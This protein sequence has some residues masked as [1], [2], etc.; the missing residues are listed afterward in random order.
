MECVYCHKL[1]SNKYTLRTH[2]TTSKKCIA[3]QEETTNTVLQKK[4]LCTHCNKQLTSNERLQHHLTICKQRPSEEEVKLRE[5]IKELEDKL[6]K[7][8]MEPKNIHNTT[9][10]TNMSNSNNTNNTNISIINYM[11]EERVLQIFKDHFQLKDLEQSRLGMF[12][13]KH[14]LTGEDKPVYKCTD[15][16]RKRCVYI[17][18][19][20]N[21]TV[22]KN[23]KTLINL[24]H[25]ANPYVKELIQDDIIDQEEDVITTL[26]SDYKDYI[27][28][29]TDG[30]EFKSVVAKCASD[31]PKPSKLLIDDIDW[32]INLKRAKVKETEQKDSTRR[33]ASDEDTFGFFS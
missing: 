28:L 6:H 26:R 20:G 24:L 9:N 12:T 3:I 30:S 11:T 7:H 18:T 14:M 1:Y 8:E 33:F 2:Q 31:V 13:V 23:M 25:Q 10:I 17:D 22:D 21:E 4:F 5:R 15:L 27:N 29:E 19:S 32:D 16:S